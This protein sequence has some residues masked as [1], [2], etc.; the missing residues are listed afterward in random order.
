MHYHDP[1]KRSSANSLR[2]ELVDGTILEETVEYPIGHKRR[3]AEG[4]PLLEE[5]FETD[6]ARRFPVI[7][8]TNILDVSL[9]QTAL[10]NIPVHRYVDLYIP[11]SD[12]A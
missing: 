3:R 12:T 2:V 8:Q 5:K 4:I 7:Q 11:E 9:D 10:E 6:L 1:K